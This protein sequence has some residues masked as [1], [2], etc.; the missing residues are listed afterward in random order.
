MK[1]KTYNNVMKLAK[2]ISKKGYDLKEA[3]ELAIK[4]FDNA[5]GTIYSPEQLADRIISKEQ[6]KHEYNIAQ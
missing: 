2:Q 6:F 4:C 1:R 5:E 3:A